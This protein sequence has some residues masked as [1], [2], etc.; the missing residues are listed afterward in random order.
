[1]SRK[2]NTTPVTLGTKEGAFCTHMANKTNR[3]YARFPVFP[4]LVNVKPMRIPD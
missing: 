2:V 4:Q 1:M 3:A